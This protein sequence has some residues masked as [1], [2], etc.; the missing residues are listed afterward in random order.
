ME[1][2]TKNMIKE[3][4]LITQGAYRGVPF[5]ILTGAPAR[6]GCWEQ[7]IAPRLAQAR[8]ATL[9][10][11][12]SAR[13]HENFLSTLGV[14]EDGNQAL[15]DLSQRKIELLV[16]NY[17]LVHGKE[18]WKSAIIHH[19]ND[20]VKLTLYHLNFA[21]EEAMPYMIDRFFR[22]MGAGRYQNNYYS[23][24]TQEDFTSYIFYRDGREITEQNYDF[25]SQTY[26]QIQ[27]WLREHQCHKVTLPGQFPHYFIERY[28]HL[29]PDKKSAAHQYTAGVI[30]RLL[31]RRAGKEPLRVPGQEPPTGPGSR[32]GNPIT[33]WSGDRAELARLKKYYRER[34]PAAHRRPKLANSLIYSN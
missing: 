13:Q 11:R 23:R 6:L 29:F 33:L 25:C 21:L 14:L 15:Y 28:H 7:V 30:D 4:D 31:T 2:V 22:L 9:I 16:K 20:G 18:L 10:L 5:E 32:P 24:E 17:R 3:E 12:E 1:N 34:S 8:A 27:S 19:D 26:W